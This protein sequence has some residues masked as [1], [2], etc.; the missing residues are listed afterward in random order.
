M[1]K[2]I[3]ARTP[4]NGAEYGF[5]TVE[6]ARRVFPDAEIVRY[7]DGTPL[8]D[9]D[10]QTA[11]ETAFDADKA[12]RAQLE[13][14]AAEVGIEDAADKKVYPKVDDLRAA[15][16]AALAPASPD[17]EVPATVTEADADSGTVD[18][19]GGTDSGTTE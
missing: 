12:T 6:D 10:L 16:K 13:E 4:S 7:Q 19:A 1:S 9:E 8:S 17:L 3:V 2:P 5:E 11:E 14:F 18:A 15:V